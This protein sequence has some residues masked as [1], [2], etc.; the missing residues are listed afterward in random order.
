MASH[1]ISKLE[2]W[3][4]SNETD[5]DRVRFDE[6]AEQEHKARIKQECE[7]QKEKQLV[8]KLLSPTRKRTG[9][10]ADKR[11]TTVDGGLAK[12][13]KRNSRGRR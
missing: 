12:P 2:E 3:T 13:E 9:S 1:T 4:K 7:A 10:R 8:N 5:W 11:A 6:A